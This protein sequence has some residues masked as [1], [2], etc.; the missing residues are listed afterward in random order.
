MMKGGGKGRGKRPRQPSASHTE[1]L[2]SPFF[3]HH[4]ENETMLEVDA[5]G[6]CSRKIA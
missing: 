4:L 2:D 1:N 5:S 6:V 3:F